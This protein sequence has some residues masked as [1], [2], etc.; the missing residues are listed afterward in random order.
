MGLQGW[1]D[2]GQINYAAV[3]VLHAGPRIPQRVNS[4]QVVRGGCEGLD[5]ITVAPSCRDAAGFES[6]G[7]ISAPH[8]LR[9]NVNPRLLIAHAQRHLAKTVV[10]IANSAQ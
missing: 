1:F 10:V 3:V 5:R 6:Q 9:V 4:C 7:V 8:G 2:S